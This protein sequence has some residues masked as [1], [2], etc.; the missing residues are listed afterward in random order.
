M[1]PICIVQINYQQSI[2]IVYNYGLSLWIMNLILHMGT[3]YMFHI[4]HIDWPYGL[5][6]ILSIFY[7]VVDISCP[8]GLWITLFIRIIFYHVHILHMDYMKHVVII[9]YPYGLSIIMGFPLGLSYGS[10]YSYG[11]YELYCLL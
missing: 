6:L 11:L 7:H 1:M 5:W 9:D 3:G 2:W 8:Y 10:Y 4:V